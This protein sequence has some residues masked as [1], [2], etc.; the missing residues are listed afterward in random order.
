MNTLDDTLGISR[1]IAAPRDRVWRAR[2]EPQALQQWWW[3]SRFQTTYG[4]DLRP[5]GSYRFRTADV[6]DLGV[7][8]VSG[9]FLEIR[10]LERLEYTWK[11]EGAENDETR[12][13]VELVDHDGETEVR[14]THS[15]FAS[16]SERDNHIVGWGDCLDR[17]QSLMSTDRQT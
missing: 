15:G 2:T 10:P 16:T 3:P 4:V 11:W 9:R 12:V 14:V 17:L 6:P 8:A 1:R 13:V 7:L 5:G